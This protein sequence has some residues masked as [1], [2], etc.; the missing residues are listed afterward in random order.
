MLHNDI[1]QMH[2]TLQV[3]QFTNF[4]NDP[5]SAAKS[6]PGVHNHIKLH[7]DN[8]RVQNIS[9]IP[10]NALSKSMEFSNEFLENPL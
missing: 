5:K 4:Q 6:A 8:R 10:V 3:I 1:Q 2:L 7:K 9:K